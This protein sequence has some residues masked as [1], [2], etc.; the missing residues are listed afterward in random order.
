MSTGGIMSTGASSS[1][2]IMLTPRLDD[3]DEYAGQPT[4][5]Q[6]EFSSP[7]SSSS[8]H[9]QP[10]PSQVLTPA[11]YEGGNGSLTDSGDR[12]SHYKRIA[13]A[14]SVLVFLNV[15]LL[16]GTVLV[17]TLCIRRRR[18]RQYRHNNHDISSPGEREAGSNS[19]DR[20]A[21]TYAES[22]PLN[23]SSSSDRVSMVSNTLYSRSPARG[24]SEPPLQEPC[25]ETPEAADTRPAVE[26]MIYNEAY[27]SFQANRARRKPGCGGPARQ[28][29]ARSNTDSD[30]YEYVR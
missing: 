14:A 2:S 11:L 23:R 17:T 19:S 7:A 29:G 20:T 24:L 30:G 5:P 12:A 6:P 22:Q 1:P 26:S 15:V 13:A 16:A 28:N 8:T 27:G 21:S 18:R 4:R 3:R 10:A 25:R 9:H